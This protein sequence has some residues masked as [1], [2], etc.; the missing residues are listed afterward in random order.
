MS[1]PFCLS[2]KISKKMVVYSSVLKKNVSYNI[3]RSCGSINQFPMPSLAEIRD[4]YESYIDIKGEMNPGY[5]SEENLKPF[6]AERD[7]TLKE[8]G[9]SLSLIRERNNLEFGC[10]NGQ[11]LRYLKE[12]G[13]ENITGIDISKKLIDSIDIDKVNLIAG[14]FKNIKDNSVD[15]LYMFNVLE[16]INDIEIIMGDIVRVTKK[17]SFILIEIPLAGVISSYFGNKWR[18][19]MPDEHLHIPSLFGFKKIL[20]SYGLRISG[21]TRFGSGFTTGMINNKIKRFFDKM[22]KKLKFGD[23]CAFLINKL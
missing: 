16:H 18:F 13:G 20:S 9:F 4:Y 8:I 15:N 22:A 17:D 6:F 21:M 2:D 7:K 10:A 3:C 1:C 14:D 12:K 5:L 23:R 19:L 11:F